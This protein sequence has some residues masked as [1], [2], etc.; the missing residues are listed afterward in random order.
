MKV[1]QFAILRERLETMGESLWNEKA[2]LIRCGN[3]F[4]VPVKEGGRALPDIYSH[5]VNFSLEATHDLTFGI[6]RVLEMQPT[7]SPFLFCVGVVDLGDGF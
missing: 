4:S 2:S 7:D 3:Y 1:K 5:I 6:W